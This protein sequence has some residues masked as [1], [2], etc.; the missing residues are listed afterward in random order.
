MYEAKSKLRA[1]R[2]ENLKICGKISSFHGR[3]SDPISQEM[4][5]PF[6]RGIC[7][8]SWIAPWVETTFS[9][10]ERGEGFLIRYPFGYHFLQRSLSFDVTLGSE[11]DEERFCVWVREE[12]RKSDSLAEREFEQASRFSSLV[13]WEGFASDYLIIILDQPPPG[14]SQK[15]LEFF[16]KALQAIPGEAGENRASEERDLIQ[17][18][19]KS[20]ELIWL[21]RN[22]G[23]I[24][25]GAQNVEAY[26]ATALYSLALHHRL[27]AAEAELE[28]QKREAL[29]YLK[30]TGRATPRSLGAQ[31]GLEEGT[32]KIYRQSLVLLDL[33]KRLTDPNGFLPKS[34]ELSGRIYTVLAERFRLEEREEN[35]WDCQETLQDLFDICWDRV[36]EFKYFFYEAAFEIIIVVI[37]LIDFLWLVFER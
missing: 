21:E 14:L 25:A 10:S 3:V 2:E 22:R 17:F 1:V 18:T 27:E 28:R 26:Q 20:Q 8:S 11:Q 6:A 7:P 24:A 32:Q 15:T 19:L 23:L 16:Q 37:L 33:S 4:A 29:S 12:K 36:S 9:N 34:W 31:R 30:Y 5:P 35:A 13:S